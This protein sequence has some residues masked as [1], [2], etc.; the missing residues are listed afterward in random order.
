[1]LPRIIRQFLAAALIAATLGLNVITPVAAADVTVFAAA[2]LRDALDDIGAKFETQ[3]GYSLA[4]SLAGSSLLARQIELGAPADIYFPANPDWMN[5][6]EEKGLLAPD[7]RLDLLGNRLVLVAPRN[8]AQAISSFQDPLLLKQLG[9]GK[10]AMGLVS[11]VPAGIYGK[12]ALQSLGIW[13]DLEGKIAQSDNVRA[14]LAMVAIGEAPLGVV[15]ASDVIAEPRVA[16]LAEFPQTSHPPILYPIAKLKSAD[17]P[18][19]EAFYTFLQAPETRA[20]FQAA[21]FETIAE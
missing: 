9:E 1:M 18:A 19:V 21:G 16:I 5:Y 12:A 10:L 3:T 2:S 14:A 8:S 20:V 13:Q 11:A 17:H 7:S 15:Y 4:L 6:L